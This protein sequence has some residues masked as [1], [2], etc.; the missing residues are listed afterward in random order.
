MVLFSGRSFAS[1]ETKETQF[2][3]SIS[4]EVGW[5]GNDGDVGRGGKP[6]KKKEVEQCK[7]PN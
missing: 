4:D 1:K 7:G 6:G 2:L 3:I 5:G